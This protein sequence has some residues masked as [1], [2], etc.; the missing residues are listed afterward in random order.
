MNANSNFFAGLRLIF[1]TE[2]TAIDYTIHPS[3]QSTPSMLKRHGKKICREVNFMAYIH[4]LMYVPAYILK[5]IAYL[6]VHM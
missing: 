6:Y 4:L 1:K 3:I 2:G 5:P